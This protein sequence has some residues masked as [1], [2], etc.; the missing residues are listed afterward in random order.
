MPGNKKLYL[1][2]NTNRLRYLEVNSTLKALKLLVE[3]LF[4]KIN[5]Q[6]CLL[7]RVAFYHHF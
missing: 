3:S 1:L 4:P 6:N 7:V 2:K 5:L